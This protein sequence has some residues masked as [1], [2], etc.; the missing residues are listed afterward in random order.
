MLSDA[1][2]YTCNVIS[3][4]LYYHTNRFYLYLTFRQGFPFWVSAS[5]SKKM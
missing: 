3:F 2:I 5:D 1:K 4:V